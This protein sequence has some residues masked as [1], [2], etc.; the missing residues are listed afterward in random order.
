MS[1]KIGIGIIGTGAVA[2]HH[3][4]SVRE[5]EGCELIGLASSTQERAKMMAERWGIR[6]Y[7]DYRN[8]LANNDI[9]AVIIC[10]HSG[11][12]MEPVVAAARA[13][14]HVLVEKP[15]EVSLQRADAMIDACREAG[16]KFGC[17]FQNRFSP[18]FQLLQQAVAEGALGKL[19]LGNAYIKWY[20]APEYYQS[21]FWK[22]TFAGDGG[23]ALINQGIHTI[24][25]L[26]AVMGQAESVFGKVKTVKHQIEGEDLGVALVSFSNGALGTVEGSTAIVP[27][28][29]ER[30]EIY[31]T[32]G[33]VILEGGK[34]IAW[35]VPAMERPKPAAPEEKASGAADPMAI[36]HQ[37]H[38]IQIADFLDAIRDDRPPAVTGEEGRR[39]LALILKIYESAKKG[40]EVKV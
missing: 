4:K 24:D 11:N 39:A 21:S 18:D 38:K 22:G 12:H 15:L 29:P 3:I 23:A 25:L 7:G 1:K 2:E 19:T 37:L 14:K 34:I 10:T 13:G 32:R 36:G 26:L 17:V 6:T 35:N 28:Y 40:K 16:V 33:S 9:R 5:L 31:G 27:G 20:R 30:L 8:L